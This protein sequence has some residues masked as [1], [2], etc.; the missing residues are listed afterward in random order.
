MTP[1]VPLIIIGLQ[2]KGLKG[3]LLLF[4]FRLAFVSPSNELTL[5]ASKACSESRGPD[6]CLTLLYD[7]LRGCQ[8]LVGGLMAPYLDRARV[9]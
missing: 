8:S 6:E 3:R 5:Q 4:L 9:S 1:P 7:S 2:Q